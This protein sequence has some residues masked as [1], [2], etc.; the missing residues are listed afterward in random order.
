MVEIRAFLRHYRDQRATF[1]L[2]AALSLVGVGFEAVLLVVLVPLAQAISGVADPTIALGPFDL[3]ARSTGELLLVALG[4]IVVVTA[5]QLAV[6]W[7]SARAAAEWQHTWRHRVFRAFLDA[8]WEVQ[9]RDRDGKLVAITGINIYQGAAGLT[10]IASGLTAVM[11]LVVMNVTAIVVAPIGALLMLVC[12]SVLFACLHP[13]TRYSKRRFERMAAFNLEVSNDLSEMASLAREVRLH[14]VTDRVDLVVGD[15]LQR[16]E[17]LRRRATVLVNVGSPLYR[18]GGV[19]LVLGLIWFATSRD[20]A[21]AAA[22]ST[23]ALLLY[24]SVGYGQALQRS[25]HAVHETLPFLRNTDAELELYESHRHVV[26]AVELAPPDTVELQGVAYAYDDDGPA[27]DGVSVTMRRGEIIGLAGRSGAGKTTLAQILLRLRRPTAGAVLVDGRPAEDFSD[28][29][30]A[31]QVALVPQDTRLIHGTV[32]ENI[33]FLRED[34]TRAAVEHAAA[35]AGIHEAIA[36]LPQGYDT[37]IGPSTRNLSGGQIQRVGIARAL[38][39]EPAILVL[40]EPTSALDA[41]SEQVIQDTL[42]QLRGRLLVVIIAHRL[43]TLSI[44]SRVLVMERG[45][46]EAEGPPSEVLHDGTLLSVV[47]DEAPERE[48][49]PVAGEKTAS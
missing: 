27:L 39:G 36:A 14:G 6:V 37:P 4:A 45:R 2:I 19:V 49:R 1:A 26:G 29:S 40:D 18:L 32:A 34:I 42:E 31:A 11:G 43:T 3:S 22:F 16:H 20:A 15:Q 41:Q 10:S 48:P 7:L 21:G 30:W 12:G 13:L 5:V 38:A 23:A 24:R 33:A 28:E 35:E 46:L 25:Y 17:D 47:T 9:S 8:D 44:C